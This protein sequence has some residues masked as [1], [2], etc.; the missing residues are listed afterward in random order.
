M[1]QAQSVIPIQ[2]AGAPILSRSRTMRHK[3]QVG[4]INPWGAMRE[5]RRHHNAQ[6]MGFRFPEVLA[7]GDL[8][9]NQE[10]G[11]CGI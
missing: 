4:D 6:V 10:L 8:K 2:M 11:R 5:I 3:T 9:R 7:A 1:K